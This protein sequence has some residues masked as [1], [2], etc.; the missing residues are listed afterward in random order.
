MWSFSWTLEFIKEKEELDGQL[1]TTNGH[2]DRTQG[3]E[4]PEDAIFLEIT[5]EQLIPH[6][7]TNAHNHFQPLYTWKNER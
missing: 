5:D 4:P 6:T 1:G 3:K 7:I 2:K